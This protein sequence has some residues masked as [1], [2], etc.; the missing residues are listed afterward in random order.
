MKG[1]ASI[2]KVPAEAKPCIIMV[3][4]FLS[5]A[6][7]NPG[8]CESLAAQLVAHGW[9]VITTS[10]Q[11]GRLARLLDMVYTVLRTRKFYHLAQVDV[12]SR[13][14]FFWA[15]VVCCFLNFLNKPFILTLHSGKLPEFAAQWPGRVRRLLRPAT[16]VTTPSYYLLDKMS[17]YRTELQLLPN[18]IDLNKYSFRVRNE[19]RPSLIWLRAFHHVYNPQLVPRVLAVLTSKFSDTQITM[20]GPDKG[21]GSLQSTKQAAM[22][23]KVSNRLV[24]T[25]GI[26]KAEVPRM[27][28]AGDIFLNTTNEDNTPISVMEAMACGLCVVSTNVGGVPYLLNHEQDALLVPPEN[29]EAMAA[30]VSRILTEPSLAEQLS[31]NARKKAEQFDWSVILPKWETLLMRTIGLQNC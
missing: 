15:E 21:D 24:I 20:I 5:S 8:V 9:Q 4:N 16:V 10:R 22:E 12:H 26:P 31:C 1:E 19:P 7:L 27:I 11:H 17:A 6:G 28:S 25:G 2:Q 18:A 14:A 13:L 3:S 30:A 23:L 29:P